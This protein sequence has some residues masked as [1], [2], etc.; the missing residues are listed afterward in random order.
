MNI[1][2]LAN[3]GIIDTFSP[4]VEF[5]MRNKELIEP[6]NKKYIAIYNRTRKRRIKKKQVKKSLFLQMYQ[7]CGLSNIA[8]KDI[9]ICVGGKEI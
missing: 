2:R 8:K 9:K 1:P 5:P 6:L 3:G 4:I 7:F